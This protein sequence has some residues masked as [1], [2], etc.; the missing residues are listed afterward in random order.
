MPDLV[1]MRAAHQA[2]H[3][4]FTKTLAE[5][6]PGMESAHW[7]RAC[8]AV[9]GENIR[10][11]DDT[12]QDEALASDSVLASLHDEYIRLLH[13]FYVARDGSGGVLGGLG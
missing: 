13:V 7:Y 2:A 3:A 1:A 5:R 11:N 12:S 10:R 8:A 6:Y 9:K 4:A